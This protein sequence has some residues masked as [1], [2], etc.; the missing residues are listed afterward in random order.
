M[1]V[2]ETAATLV[3]VVVVLLLLLPRSSVML[4]IV[5]GDVMVRIVVGSAASLAFVMGLLRPRLSVFG[6][7]KNIFVALQ[8]T[9]S[10]VK[11]VAQ[12]NGVAP[13]PCTAGKVGGDEVQRRF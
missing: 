13:V 8:R 4:A 11:L 5:L 9:D 1:I 12:F 10:F 6:L 2:L 3:M 7:L